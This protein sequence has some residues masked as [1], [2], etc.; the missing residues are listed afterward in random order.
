MS[1]VHDA[2]AKLD[3]LEG[4]QAEPWQSYHQEK[5]SGL[6]VF[7]LPNEIL[8]DFYD[9]R[10]YIRIANLRGKV[11]V[12]SIAS[13]VNGEGSST[14]ATYLSFLMAGGQIKK[15]GVNEPFAPPEKDIEV[16]EASQHSDQ[17]FDSDFQAIIKNKPVK[18]T[19]EPKDAAR[20]GQKASGNGN[21]KK[22]KVLLVDGNLHMPGLHRFFGLDPDDG[23]AEIIEYEKDWKEFVKPI[24]GVQLD[25]ITAGRTDQN[26]TE[27]LSSDYFRIL[28]A[29]WRQA[30]KYVI[31]DS[32]PVLSYVDAMSLAAIV[33]GVVLVI[34]AGQTRWEVAQRAKRKLVAAHA[35]LLGVT[36]NRRK[37]NIPDGAYERLV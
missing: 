3:R 5:K 20:Q 31:F 37:V 14:I 33:D 30:Y 23:L 22:Q 4:Q 27:L 10:E 25:F 7:D 28:V 9:L 16:K 1:I 32:P 8:N 2:L 21:G 29:Q 19:E 18:H 26:P 12:I 17:V 13:S 24:K 6:F 15:N 35:N 11:R 36:L 34:R